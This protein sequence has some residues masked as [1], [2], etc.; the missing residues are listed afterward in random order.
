MYTITIHLHNVQ[1][2]DSAGEHGT[3]S[4][5]EPVMKPELFEYWEPEPRLHR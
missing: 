2:T 1:Q 3:G 5:K 4:Y